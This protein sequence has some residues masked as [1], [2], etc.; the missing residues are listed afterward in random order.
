M[1][2]ARQPSGPSTCASAPPLAPS[3]TTATSRQT[4]RSRGSCTGV[5]GAV[6]VAPARR[7]A[8]LE[9]ADQAWGGSSHPGDGCGPARRA[10]RDPP[11]E[12]PTA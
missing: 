11:V 5:A 1:P 12:D 6:H 4:H 8:Q 7:P 9:W 2:V 3:S 10:A